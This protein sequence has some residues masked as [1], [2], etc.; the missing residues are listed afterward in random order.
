[1]IGGAEVY[2]AALQMDECRRI[3]RTKIDK[4]FECD[5]YFPVDLEADPLWR[6]SSLEELS[7]WVGEDVK[8]EQ[9]QEQEQDDGDGDGKGVVRWEYQMWER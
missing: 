7:G 8:P 1:M 3:L 6:R 2:R 5:V 4:E 9:E